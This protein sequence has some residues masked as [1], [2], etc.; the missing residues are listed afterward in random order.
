MSGFLKGFLKSA[1][2][3]CFAITIYLF[4]VLEMLS[5][6]GRRIFTSS[7]SLKIRILYHSHILQLTNVYSK[8]LYVIFAFIVILFFLTS[9]GRLPFDKYLRF[10]IVQAILLSIVCSCFG[11]VYTLLPIW[12]RNTHLIGAVATTSFAFI[13][14]AAFYSII[15]VIFGRYPRIPVISRAARMQVQRSYLDF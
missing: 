14:G 8:Y 5:Y 2:E 4:P 15:L 11:T 13:V 7:Q 6:V 1:S 12:L 9:R 10:N 3:R